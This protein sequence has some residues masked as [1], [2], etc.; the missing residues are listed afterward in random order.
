MASSHSGE[1]LHVRTLQGIFRRAG[2][3]QTRPRLRRR[4]H[5]ARRADR[6][7]A[8]P[9]RREA[10]S[11][12]PHVLGPARVDPPAGAA[13]RLAARD[14]LAGRPSGAGRLPAR[15]RARLRND[16][17]PPVAAIDGCGVPTYAF[18][19]RESRGPT[20]SWPTRR[21]SPR[22][23]PRASGAPA[24]TIIRDAMLAN[25]EMVA[26]T[27]ERLDT[28]LMKAVPGR[29]VSKG[30]KEACGLAILAGA[31]P[32]N[33]RSARPRPRAWRQDRGRR[34]PR[35]RVL[36][37]DGRGASPGRRPRRRSPSASSRAITG[38]RSLDPHGRTAPRRSRS[39]SSRPSAS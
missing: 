5:A 34:R 1:D 36:G 3:S 13:A 7:P 27:R 22:S 29:I 14:L 10:Q 25:P 8:G 20:R 23:D 19:L 9:R 31:R 24:L 30:G 37:G 6:R 21:P 16:A 38:R 26:G 35:A 4:G 2:V 17:R 11:D 39:S 28:S 12:P 32:G 15:G 18:P 33:G